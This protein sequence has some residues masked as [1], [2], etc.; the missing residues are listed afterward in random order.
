M[1]D[2]PSPVRSSENGV[3]VSV[4][5]VPGA[6]RPG[7]DGMYDGV[8]RLRVAAPPEGGTA[9]REVARRV[10]TA[11]GG[12]SGDIVIG[13]GSRRKVVEVAGVD[14]Q[15]AVEGLRQEGVVW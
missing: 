15:G 2:A 11:C 5:V 6:S 1:P 3:L 12:R 9:N 14:V 10:A 4:W 8:V 13:G 7:F